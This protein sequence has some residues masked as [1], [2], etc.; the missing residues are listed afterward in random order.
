MAIESLEEVIKKAEALT[1]EEQLRLIIHLAENVRQAQQ[2][3]EPRRKWREIRGVLSSPAL[4][5]DA[6]VWISRLR[7]EADRNAGDELGHET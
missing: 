1:A 4:G 5:E 6:Q 3:S 7:E 2:A